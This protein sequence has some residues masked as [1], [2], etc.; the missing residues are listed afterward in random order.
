[1]RAASHILTVVTAAAPLLLKG[2]KFPGGIRGGGVGR[3]QS[4]HRQQ[5]GLRG[6]GAEWKL[7]SP[8]EAFFL[9]AVSDSFDMVDVGRLDQLSGE[10]AEQFKVVHNMGCTQDVGYAP[11]MRGCMCS[12]GYRRDN[13][14]MHIVHVLLGAINVRQGLSGW[15][16]SAIPPFI[17]TDQGDCPRISYSQNSEC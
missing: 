15:S 4:S 3:S 12:G 6:D 2:Y 8:G 17:P 14:V 16:K 13:G 9:T 10:R 7:P 1:M 5:P 11:T